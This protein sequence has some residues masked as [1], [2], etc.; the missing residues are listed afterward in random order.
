MLIDQRTS[1]KN[2]MVIGSTCVDIIIN[3]DHLPQTE[4]DIHPTGQSMAL[5]GCA[6]NVASM[7]KLFSAPVTLVSPVGTGFYGEYV[8]R[9]LLNNGFDVKIHV[10]NKDNGCCYCLVESTGERTFMS[11]H[12]A[13]Y[14]FQKSWMADFDKDQYDMVYVCGLE[15]EEPTGIELIEYLEAHPERELFYAPGPRGIQIPI[16]KAERIYALHPILHINQSEAKELSGCSSVSAAAKKLSLLTD[17]TVIITLGKNGTYCQECSG[18]S[19]TIAGLSAKVIDTIG[20][21]DSHIGA[22]MACLSKGMSYEEAILTANAVAA[23]VVS[24]KGASLTKEE[25]EPIYPTSAPRTP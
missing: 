9:N 10:P 1:K 12:G 17:N 14:L 20:A 4:E 5:G 2:I 25:F 7:I 23:Q 13:E 22:I 24:V 6:Y 18:K 11:Y 8:E 15:I 16:E 3:I 19:Y 21:G